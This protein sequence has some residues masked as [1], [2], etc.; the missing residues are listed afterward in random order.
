VIARTTVSHPSHQ[1]FG[2]TSVKHAADLEP[3]NF[4]FSTWRDVVKDGYVPDA[5][6]HLPTHS[7]A[8]V[9][10]LT[11][12]PSCVAPKVPFVV[13]VCGGAQGYVNDLCELTHK[14]SDGQMM[15]FSIDLQVGGHG[16]NITLEQ[17]VGSRDYVPPDDL[18]LAHHLMAVSGRE[19]RPNLRLGQVGEGLLRLVGR[20]VVGFD[21]Q[22]LAVDCHGQ[23]YHFAADVGRVCI[24]ALKP[25]ATERTRV[26]LHMSA[27]N[28]GWYWIEPITDGHVIR[29]L[30]IKNK[31]RRSP[32]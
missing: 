9:P 17:R 26:R 15:Y 14:L 28:L 19:L 16:H 20:M 31:E 24:D 11:W 22:D 1:P 30:L 4:D 25:G 7:A 29:E 3:E 2:D 23:A 6:T 8:P 13:G 21:A 12:Q 32:T 10:R 5:T 18:R 27:N